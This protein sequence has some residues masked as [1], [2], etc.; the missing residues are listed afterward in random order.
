MPQV[1]VAVVS[2]IGTVGATTVAAVAGASALSAI[3]VGAMF[4]IG[5][6]VIAG[7]LMLAN[8]MISSLYEMPKM[9]TD[10]SRQ[11]TVKG[12][13]EPQKILYGQN[14]VSGPISFVG[15]YGDT[16][17]V[18]A[19]AVVLAG[20]E[21]EEIVDIYFD[22]EVITDSQ[23]DANGY[24]TSGTFGP[25]GNK[26][27]AFGVTNF[28]TNI[29]KINRYTGASGQTADPDLVSNFFSYT[30]DHVGT[31]L[32]YITTHW[33]LK[34]GSQKTW[35]QYSP[36]NI[37]ATVKGRKVYDPRTTLTAYSDNPALCLADYLTNT[38]FGMGI[39]SAKIDW[40]SVEAAANACDVTVSVPSGT[41]KRFACNGVLFGTDSHKTNINKILSS[42]NGLL[43]FTNGKY[44]IRAGV[45][46]AP[47]V[48]LDEDNL[49]GAVSIKT[50][51]ERSDRFNTV[52]G[53]FIDPA[54]NYKA[55]EFP[56][57]QLTAALLRDNG[58]VLSK[59]IQLPMTNSSYMAQRIAHKL[60]QISDQ[61]KVV[62]FPTNLAGMQI[63]IGDRVSVSLEEFNWSNKVFI[64]LGWTFS[65][66]GNGG[67]N[68]ILRE[69]DSGSYAD[70][71]VGEYSTISATGGII[72]GFKGFP[73]PQNLTATAGL[74]SVEL[75]WDNP[76]NMSDIEQIEVFASPNSNWA[77][78]VKIGSVS[79]TQFTHDESNAVDSV[80]IGDTR[81]YWVRARGYSVGDS[82]EEVSD[83]NPDND[84]SSITA[85][86]GAL[87]W[88]DVAGDD[89]PEDNATLGATIGTDLKDSGSNIVN[90]AE[91]LNSHDLFRIT[92]NDNLAPDGTEFSTAAGRNPKTG[93]IVITTDTTTTPDTTYAWQY[94][95]TSWSSIANLISGDLIVDGSITADQIN[96]TSVASAVITAGSI[97]VT[98][99]NISDL[100]NDSG[101]NNTYIDGNGDI[102]GVS[103]GA[104]TSVDN[105]LNAGKTLALLL[106][107][108]VSGVSNSGECALVAVDNEGNIDRTA[109]GY[110]LWSGSK[111]T[112]D[113][114]QYASAF[115]ILTN[116]ANKRGFICFDTTKSDPFT[117]QSTA[118]D[119]A[120]VYKQGSQW[121]YDNNSS[122]PTSF[123]PTDDM[124]ALGWLETGVADQVVRGGLFGEPV[125]LTTASFPSDVIE[126]GTVGGIK[127]EPTKL[128]E[129]TGTFNNANT[130]FYLDSSGQFSLKDKLSFNGTN[131]SVTGGITATSLTLS[132]ITIP[133]T[134]LDSSVQTSLDSADSALQ[135]GDISQIISEGNIPTGK[136]TF[137]NAGPRTVTYSGNNITSSGGADNSWNTHV[138]SSEHYDSP[139]VL[140]FE[141]GYSSSSGLRIMVG[142]NT[143]PLTNTS[144]TSIDYAWYLNSGSA[145]IYT[146]G[147]QLSPDGGSFSYNTG[148]KFSIVYDGDNILFYFNNILKKT[149]L[150]VGSLD[151]YMDSSIY[152]TDTIS[153]NDVRFAPISR[154]DYGS[155]GSVQ[156][157][158]EKLYQGAGDFNS[159][160]TGFY[161]DSSG[162]FSLKNKLSF[163]GTD[164]V[165]DGG[166]KAT[167]LDVIDATVTGTLN[168]STVS[169]GSIKVESLSQGVWNAIDDRFTVVAG[170]S[171]GFYET[172]TGV[173]VG[174]EITIATPQVA[175]NT[176]DIVFQI[177]IDQYWGSTTN[178]TG[179][180]LQATVTYEYSTDNVNWSTVTSGAT[181]ATTTLTATNYP[182][183]YGGSTSY[184][185]YLLSGYQF[186]MPYA[187]LA[188]GNYY[189]R[190]RITP[191]AG[192][193]AFQL[194]SYLPDG[195]IPVTYEANEAVS[196]TVSTSGN[197]NTLDGLDS[198]QFLRS[199]ADDSTSGSLS[200][201]GNLTVTGDLTV[202]G[203]TT[204]L[205]TATLD[206]EDKN[207]TLNFGA[208]DTSAS[209][210]GAGITIQ[211]A[212]DASTDATILWDATNDEFDFSH[213]LTA[214]KFYARL[215]A[216]SAPQATDYIYIGGD[217]LAGADASIYIGNRGDGTGYGWRLY[218]AGSG[219]GNNNKLIIRSENLGTS[220]DALTFTA[221]GNA[222]FVGTITASGYNNSNWDTAYGWGNH[223]T[224]GYL[225]SIPTPVVG[226]FWNGGFVQVGTDGVMEVGKYLDFHAS[227]S[228]GNNDYDLRVT[229][230]AGA[231]SVGGTLSSG[232]FSSSG[233]VTATSTSAHRLGRISF[234]D[235]S[236]EQHVTD[237][238]TAGIA[239]N[240]N[241]YGN[242]GAYF[243]DVNF[244]DGKQGFVGRIDGSAKTL[245][246]VNG[247]QVNGTT[248]I[249]SSRRLQNVS[250]DNYIG[251]TS[252]GTTQNSLHANA[253]MQMNAG[254]GSVL[255][256]GLQFNVALFRAPR[257]YAK[258]SGV[259]SDLGLHPQLTDGKTAND[260]SGVTLSRSYDE[261]IF[262]FGS[263][264]GYTFI[265]ALTILHSTSGNSMTIY[266]ESSETGGAT[267]TG[268]TE[269][270]NTGAV[271]SWPGSTT[272][273]RN[274]GIG[275]GY[276]N[277]FRIRIVPNFSHASNSISL[278]QIVIRA[279]YGGYARLFDWDSSRNVDFYGTVNAVSG[280]EVN[281]TTVIDSSRNLTNIG[282]YSGSGLLTLTNTA[283]THL[284]IAY[285]SSFYWDIYRESATGDLIFN[286]S[287]TA[288][289][290]VRF[291]AADKTISAVGGYLVN[292]TTVIDSSRNLTNIVS[293]TS[294]G[295]VTT[296]APSTANDV[297]LQT[298]D[299]SGN[300]S[301]SL[302]IHQRVT[303]GIVRYSFGQTNNNTVYDDILV[304]KQG[305]VG[306]G[307]QDPNKQ[308]QINSND[309]S[310]DVTAKGLAGG[311]AG[312]GILIYNTNMTAGSYANLDF[313]S[314]T[315]DAR[316]AYSFSGTTNVGTFSFVSDNGST[317]SVLLTLDSG[318]DLDVKTGGLQINNTTVIDSSRNLVNIGNTTISGNLQIDNGSN[319]G[320]VEFSQTS[321]YGNGTLQIQPKTIPG[322]GTADYF[323]HFANN[324]TIGS[325]GAT[326]HSISV[327]GNIQIGGTT[328]IDSSR[329]LTNIGTGSFSGTV[330]IDGGDLDIRT[331]NEENPT[332]V[333]YFGANNGASTNDSDYIG[334]GIVWAPKYTG[335]TKRSA[336]IMQIGEGNYFKS[337]LAFFTNGTSNTSTDWS[338]RMRISMDGKIGANTTSPLTQ[339]HV[340][341]SVSGTDT[342]SRTT[343]IDVLTLETENTGTLEYNGFG[344]G[345]VF[346]GSTY[347]NSAQR[348]L[349]RILHQ[350]SDDS[351]AITRGTTLSFQTSDDPTNSAA[352]TTK[353]KIDYDGNVDVSYGA[354]T[355]RGTTVI[356]S[357]RNLTNIGT[358]YANGSAVWSD[359]GIQGRSIGTIHIDP[360]SGTDHAGGAIT[361][362][363]SDVSGGSDAQAGIYIR[364]DGSYGTKMYF[365]TTDS[366]AQGAKTALSIDHVG[367]ITANR[368]SLTVAGNIIK[369]GGTSAQFL[370]ADGSVQSTSASS[371]QGSLS[372]FDAT[373]NTLSFLAN[374]SHLNGLITGSQ[375]AVL[376]L[377]TG[378]LQVT[379]QGELNIKANSITATKLAANSVTASE[380]A[381]S[382][383]SDST[384]SSIYMD[385][386]GAIKVYDSSG[387]LRVKIGNL[388]A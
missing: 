241:G 382:A 343:P 10:A 148:D 277:L 129:G 191:L 240:Y 340:Y 374:V 153:I 44:V 170:S 334:T 134:D 357:S 282:S 237:S 331:Q 199:D 55:T 39:D 135:I 106:N 82:A 84:V 336:G 268:W 28:G 59:D 87:P 40:D 355:V 291:D 178:I 369:S 101:F 128:Y 8:K 284:R 183:T 46:E 156:I 205:N 42:M 280:Y 287:N 119:V 324:G 75:N 25:K 270:H 143:D 367:N 219:S 132:G 95:G 163:D 249:D 366:Y 149:I 387:T 342:A 186:T 279:G 314:G 32:A 208:G 157:T 190:V 230:S 96:A 70:P 161:L 97:I 109:D 121:Y 337:G 6:G 235:D 365:A 194:S 196:G 165:V 185:Y 100:N 168:A 295:L 263:D 262:Y 16:N 104:G 381:I 41:E 127:I 115:T 362:G 318:G 329:N 290:F 229:A 152:D 266:I 353:L 251:Y 52:T 380:L 339:F 71:A 3:S 335:Y 30:S 217:D 278:G 4:A 43:S 110:I 253:M 327:D 122:T 348:T 74:K 211:D 73:D 243:R 60:V 323:T 13:I 304:F 177:A 300:G 53:T 81:Y 256:D 137:N 99:D 88:A 213:K 378:E 142:L 160:N 260:W 180:G 45:Y 309:S 283:N 325:G 117:A 24:V 37:K 233:T 388:S 34:D 197:A 350:I 27:F 179:T 12:T 359:G 167:T 65:D 162:Q 90:D 102:Q 299:Y 150:S 322:S 308:V 56:E 377:S 118:M 92:T 112:I 222:S 250:V 26:S 159:S 368:G 187:E 94:N 78:A 315:A 364:S 18:L 216:N 259:W 151:L 111:I 328:V 131:L 276:D 218:Y 338:E 64:C 51:F 313:R 296:V 67:V 248:V 234:R 376:D 252:G 200:V 17:R 231:L 302:D 326:R 384:A 265:S 210:N 166:V 49:I 204:T 245:N 107:E 198:T 62:T 23:I 93:D 141:A 333:I 193:N 358:I 72:T 120:F 80:A 312:S 349:G 239:F 264:L 47:A 247:Y 345:I 354:L 48:N 105:T 22:D 103:S 254:A 286:S 273:T 261:F 89:K 108:S 292:G 33:L 113:R 330:T 275:A 246:I 173:F 201:G 344:Q 232:S 215:G 289:E 294:K 225:T 29:C 21:V 269:I 85:T 36:Q 14:L 228:G 138:Y 360:A 38:D 223:A 195:G 220:V 76:D 209:A 98:G 305:K 164:L 31:G 347:N 311:V 20:H 267:D 316:I 68:L 7:G 352:P 61:Q 35:D 297:H 386:N 146:N 244:Y 83:R 63:A 293:I 19:H 9:D 174:S 147:S 155:V 1:V 66:S 371:P 139:C 126:S 169:A 356:D 189:F 140:Q 15:T 236:I 298:W 224:A 383:D 320:D 379:S 54:Q 202:N 373:N 271:G 77:S 145:T 226:D 301:Y 310:T 114:Y 341:S 255:Q 175:H 176:K 212:V 375:T 203:T 123:T 385:A 192:T 158:P 207:I 272:I 171:G 303:S 307:T 257:M 281:G 130:G 321:T 319:Y 317:P 274:F 288:G 124:V 58:E 91:V 306:F 346:R 79:G 258:A 188:A 370:K 363:A 242:A 116:L 238:D 372:P 332:D 206:V 5:A 351:N 285:N 181:N 69:D 136:L 86:V 133:K 182:F 227:D 172:D 184:I 125:S 214:P 361:F 2:F 11:R 57:V 221:D 144:Y 154:I 50:S